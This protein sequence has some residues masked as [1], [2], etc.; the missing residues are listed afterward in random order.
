[1]RQQLRGRAAM[2]A[3]RVVATISCVS[4]G[5]GGAAAQT[6]IGTTSAFETAGNW[7]PAAV[8]S[9]G[10]TATF[11]GSGVT[12]VN[13]VADRE[14]DAFSFTAAAPAFTITNTANLV[15]SGAGL[16]VGSPSP[17]T[18]ITSRTGGLTF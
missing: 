15:L 13:I 10:D 11:A 1:M 7:S 18:L 6:W 14:V 12:T 3:R 16:Q 8:P 17:Q 2:V 4:L 9:V 5:V